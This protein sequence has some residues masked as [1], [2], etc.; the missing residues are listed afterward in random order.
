MEER[1]LHAW[2]L[3]EPGTTSVMEG[4]SS[5]PASAAGPGQ[6]GPAE[7]EDRPGHPD[8]VEHS[9]RTGHPGQP[10][11]PEPTVES[12]LVGGAARL[13]VTGELTEAARRPLVRA[14]TDLLLTEP[15]LCRIA[16]DLRGVSFVN[17][18]GVAVLVQVQRLAA[19]RAIEVALLAP[20]SVVS[21]PLQLTGLWHRFVILADDEG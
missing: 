20:P 12:S 7:R 18:A 1:R 13:T 2:T 8:E 3:A 5:I 4:P 21:R 17:S 9:G 14:V 11:H 6:A 15:S 19:P 16:L 10:V